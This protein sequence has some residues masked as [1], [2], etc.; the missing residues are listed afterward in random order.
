MQDPD[1]LDC[2]I[3]D[4]LQREGRIAITELAARVALSPTACTE[5]M[6]R[7]ERDG[8]ISGYHA[9]LD[10]ARLG[11]KPLACPRPP[12]RA[13]QGEGRHRNGSTQREAASLL[14]G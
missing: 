8:V 11:R 14:S 6:R 2:R 12:S 3:L 5:R 13:S 9:W 4:V 1:R 7:L 10:P